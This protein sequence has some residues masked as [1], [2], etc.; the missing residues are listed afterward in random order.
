MAVKLK[1]S[2]R[3]DKHSVESAKDHTASNSACAAAFSESD[4]PLASSCC[5]LA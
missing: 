2:Q 3:L 5:S 4:P 1:K